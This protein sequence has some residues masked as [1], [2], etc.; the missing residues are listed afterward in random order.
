MQKARIP[1]GI[2][3]L[4]RVD[5]VPEI[6]IYGFAIIRLV[7]DPVTAQQVALAIGPKQRQ[8]VDPFDNSIVLA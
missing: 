5:Q 2:V 7:I 1:A 6:V 8:Q 4:G 3:R